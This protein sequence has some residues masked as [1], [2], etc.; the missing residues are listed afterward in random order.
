MFYEIF[1]RSFADSTSGPLADDG[2]G[3][4]AGLIERLDYLNDGDPTTD[5]DLGIGGI[6]L[7]PT[8]QAPSYHGYDVTDYYRVEKDYGTNRDFA[9]LVEEAHR[10]GI[11]ILVDLVLNH[12]SSRH[13]WFLE[14]ARER[15]P[16]HDW[17]IWSDE[18][19]DYLGPWGQPVW[20]QSPWW[21][22][23]W[24]HFNYRGYYGIFWSG[25]PDLNYRNPEV[26]A[27]M[28]EVARF[29]LEDMNVDGFRLDAVRHLI[30]DGVE[31]NDTEETHAWLRGFQA[32][33]KSVKPGA[34]LVGEIWSTAE[35]VASY[36]ADELDLAFQFQR[37]YETV[38]AVRTGSAGPLL[39]EER[40][41]RDLYERD[42]YA[43]FL[44]NH[45]QP[46]VMTQL[47]GGE[48]DAKLAATLLLTGPGVPFVYYGE[49]IGLTGIKPDPLIRRPMHWSGERHAGF[50]GHKP[51]QALEVGWSEKNVAD[52]TG[53]PDSL[54]GRYR[55]LIRLRNRNPALAVGG[56]RV[57]ESGNDHVL[58]FRRDLPN[59]SLL[60]VANLADEPIATYG[61]RLD[62]ALPAVGPVELLQGATLAVGRRE[63]DAGY[64]PLAEL[65][66]KQVYILRFSPSG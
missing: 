34:L 19:K 17:Y 7:M 22:R 9:R 4:L 21:Q 14:A 25:M 27:A 41:L 43:T 37:A 66:P 12:S 31:Q 55:K 24:K 32:F 3:D 56:H 64:R 42:R 65:P 63:A 54:L 5:E 53:D 44:T 23:G 18:K 16:R 39:A 58:A 46:R 29:W 61:I 45:D 38:T 20:H 13:P 30:E 57:L 6:W 49:E 52:Q 50:S 11:R 51:W 36:G 40:K 26:T 15:S 48:E 8:M 33:C 62:R 28:Y 59:E 47:G 60:V 2:I 10:R 35:D 1:V